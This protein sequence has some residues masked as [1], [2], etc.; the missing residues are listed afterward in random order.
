MPFCRLDLSDD[1]IG[2]ANRCLDRGARGIKLHPRAQKFDFGAR[3]LDPVFARRRGAVGADPDP[4]RPRAARDRRRSA[5]AGRAPPAAPAD[6]RP[7]RDRRPSAHRAH[8]EEPPQRHVRHV[9]LVDH[10]PARA[11][12]DRRARAGAVGQRSALRTAGGD[13]RPARPPVPV[14]PRRRPSRCTRCSGETPSG[15]AAARRPRRSS[16]RRCSNRRPA[17]HSSTAAS[18]TTSSP[19]TALLWMY[20]PDLPGALGLA[21]RACDV[22]G[23]PELADVAELIEARRRRSGTRASRS[24]TRG[25]PPR[26]CARAMRLLQVALAILDTP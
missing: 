21:V 16:R 18:P 17:G 25:R 12:D 1:P 2:E 26:T 14:R 10:R 24:R 6:P 19:T 11:A 9:G 22:D 13:D 3:G 20:Q 15:S 8:T 4:R 7:R 5:A 23:S